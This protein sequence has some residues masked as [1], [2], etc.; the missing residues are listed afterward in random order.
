MYKRVE[1]TQA[2]Y[3]KVLSIQQDD[4]A[5]L[6]FT[7]SASIQVVRI[8][9]HCVPSFHMTCL[10]YEPAGEGLL[11]TGVRSTSSL[12]TGERLESALAES[13]RELGSSVERNKH[14]FPL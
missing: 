12:W 5:L 10:P 14:L 11:C 6:A 2:T 4:V 3:A 1:K 9:L 7:A 13:R 8:A